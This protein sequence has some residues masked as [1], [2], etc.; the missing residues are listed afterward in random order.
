MVGN[1]LGCGRGRERFTSI[2]RWNKPCSAVNLAAILLLELRPKSGYQMAG[3]R[4]HLS[5]I[6]APMPNRHSAWRICAHRQLEP[7]HLMD[8]IEDFVADPC[9]WP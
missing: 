5:Q 3:G 7:I 8:V 4:L 9:S 1:C 6:F 2:L